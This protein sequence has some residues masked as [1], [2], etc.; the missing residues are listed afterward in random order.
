MEWKIGMKDD[1]R[2]VR[3]LPSGYCRDD[4]SPIEPQVANLLVG[5]VIPA[6]CMCVSLLQLS[7]TGTEYT[8]TPVVPV[9]AGA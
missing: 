3:A 2:L 7:G 8:T 9:H 5:G 6:M 1:K 4:S